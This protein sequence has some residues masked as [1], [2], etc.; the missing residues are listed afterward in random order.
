MMQLFVCLF[1]RGR[2]REALAAEERR[3]PEV[4]FVS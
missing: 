3:H 1:G 2:D 4:I